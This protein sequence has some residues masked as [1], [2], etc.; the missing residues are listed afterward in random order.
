MPATGIGH[1]GGDRVLEVVDPVQQGA[2]LEAAEHLAE[3]RAV[4]RLEHD[5]GRVEVEVEVAPHRR[6]LLRDARLVGELG[7]VL[8]PRR[9]EL[10]RVR[11]HLL[12]RAVLR[13][14]LAGGLVA[15]PG[16]ARDVVRRVALQ[17]DEV[18]HLVG[19]DAVAQLDPL[20]RVDVHVGDAARRHHQRDVR[21]AELEGVAVGRDDRRLDAGLVRAGR[22]RRDHVVR[23]PA[24]ELEVA[25]AERLD[26]RPEVRE[27]LAQEIRHRPPALLV[28]DVRG[29]GDRGPVRRARVPGDRDALRP[30]VGEQLEEHVREAE[31][32]VR[33]EAVARRELLRER[34]ERAV[35]EVVAVDEEELGVPRGAV[36]ELQLLS[37]EGLRHRPKLS[38]RGDDAPRDSSI[39]RRVPPPRRRAP[40]GAPSR[41]PRGRAAAPGAGTKTPAAAAAEVEALAR[42]EGASGAVAL[43]GSRVVGYLLGVR[44]SDEIWGA[45]VWVETAGHAVEAAEDL[46]DLYGAAAARWVEEG[47]DRHYALVPATDPALLDAWSRVSFGQQHAYGIR[48]VPDVA[49]PEGVRLAEERDLDAL[50]ELAP[51]L[52]DHQALRAGVRRRPAAARREEELRAEILEDLAKDEIG[53]LVAER[54]GRIVGA[55]QL[56]PV[57]LSSV[58]VGPRAARRAPR[59]SAGRRRARTCAARARASR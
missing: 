43:R 26:D 27:L 12:E 15:D 17:A 30:V 47:R 6:E 24:L 41:S 14:Q 16:D 34:E 13:D 49:W 29:L 37:G 25:V 33:R 35:G 20:R 58:H 5:P 1:G 44:K 23:L 48:E 45:N 8:P 54:D 21:R 57:E 36:V 22:E 7:D 3:L 51:L 28:D 9:R 2:E 11:D 46:R 59:S 31:E 52:P 40:R 53:D 4:G 56:V 39:F 19:P 10:V 55:F 50:V 38:S 18:R 42:I 32:R